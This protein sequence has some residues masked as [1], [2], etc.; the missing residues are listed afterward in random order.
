[1]SK[2]KTGALRQQEQDTRYSHSKKH[3]TQTYYTKEA[4]TINFD[5]ARIKH[6]RKPIVLVP[7]TVNQEKYILALLN[8]NTDIVP[9]RH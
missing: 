1:L 3:D 4:K 7:K 9:S 6:D 8:E 2:R 5:Q